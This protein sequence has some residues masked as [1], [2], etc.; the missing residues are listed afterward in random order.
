MKFSLITRHFRF[1]CAFYFQLLKN[2]SVV[3]V[4]NRTMDGF[5]IPFIDYDG[6]EEKWVRSEIQRLQQDFSLS[7]FY[8]FR[9]SKNGFH[10]V[11]F[12]KL[13]MG[14]Y[15][16]VLE[17]SSCDRNFKNVPLKYGKKLW[18]LRIS[19]KEEVPKFIGRVTPHHDYSIYKKSLAHILFFT[20]KDSNLVIND[21]NSDKKSENIYICQYRI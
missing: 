17:N 11:C 16:N 3:G 4:S 6:I 20:K 14:E 9:S 2:K 1:A 15:L 7:E 5:Y 18:N 19:A 8:L 10:A 13:T 21:I 12:D